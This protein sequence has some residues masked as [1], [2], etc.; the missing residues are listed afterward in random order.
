MLWTL[1][2]KQ[3]GQYMQLLLGDDEDHVL[4]VLIANLCD[5]RGEMAADQEVFATAEACSH[6]L[7]ELTV[8]PRRDEDERPP[9]EPVKWPYIRA[10]KVY[11]DSRILSKGLVLVDLPGKWLLLRLLLLDASSLC[12]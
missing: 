1:F 4:A 2:G 5:N 6:R 7:M 3:I 9:D 11:L 8:D 12:S 10:I